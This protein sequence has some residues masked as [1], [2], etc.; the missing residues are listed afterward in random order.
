MTSQSVKQVLCLSADMQLRPALRRFS[1][2][3]A[4][5]GPPDL[6]SVFVNSLPGDSVQNRVPRQVLGAAYSLVHPLPPR[7]PVCVAFSPA[8]ASQISLPST[9]VR[10][11]MCGASHG[12][13]L[14]PVAFLAFPL[15][16]LFTVP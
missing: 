9:L 12:D 3:A 16:L 8:A 13:V 4:P 11:R 1:T 14:L 7:N 2:V 5:N 15:V 10:A 6:R